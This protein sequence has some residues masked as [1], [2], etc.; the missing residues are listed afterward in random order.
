MVGKR[1]RNKTR[2]LIRTAKRK[3]FSDSISNSKDSKFIWRHLR[4]VSDNI[5]V[6]S[7][8][9]PDELIINDETFTGS[10]NVATKLNEYFTSIA[11][12]LDKNQDKSTDPDLDRLQHF[13]NSKLPEIPS[14]VSHL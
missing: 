1:Y 10:E 13:T 14:L 12:I 3:Y 9:L 5:T 8:N 6:S 2:Q 7:S 4:S 11:D